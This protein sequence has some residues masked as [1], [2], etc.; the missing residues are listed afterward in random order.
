M[1]N[2]SGDYENLVRTDE[3]L[4]SLRNLDPPLAA[5][6][7][8]GL[9]DALDDLDAAPGAAQNRLHP[10]DRELVG[11]WSLTPATPPGTLLRILLWPELRGGRGVW[12]LGPVTRHYQR[13]A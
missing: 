10:L 5:A 9:L 6:E 2:D 11:W 7:L 8:D 13:P 4:I 3:F 12:K 1:P